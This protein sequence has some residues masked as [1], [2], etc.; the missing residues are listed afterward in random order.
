MIITLI[1]AMFYFAVALVVEAIVRGSIQESRL[2][3]GLCNLVTIGL[4]GLLIFP[5][6]TTILSYLGRKNRQAM[7]IVSGEIDRHLEWKWYSRFSGLRPD[8]PMGPMDFWRGAG[9]YLIL[10]AMFSLTTI[11]VLLLTLDP[12]RIACR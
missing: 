8:R 10:A 4:Y 9:N 2:H 12:L 7:K 3:L 1:F 5:I 6:A 11:G